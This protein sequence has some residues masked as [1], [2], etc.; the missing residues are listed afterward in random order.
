MTG[1]I[2][3][4]QAKIKKQMRDDIASTQSL[5]DQLAGKQP[6][7]SK[8][9]QQKADTK[10]KAQPEKVD[11]KKL[12][13]FTDLMEEKYKASLINVEIKRDI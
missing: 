3:K 1:S 6:I 4:Q 7:G 9:L 2:K 8:K 12:K 10:T 5:A 13:K 11:T